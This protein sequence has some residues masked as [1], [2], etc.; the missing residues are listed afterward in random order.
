MARGQ[1]HSDNVGANDS[2]APESPVVPN[3]H[4]HYPPFRGVSGFVAAASMAFMRGA[5]TDLA[6]ELSALA[7]T[8]RA[9]DLGCGP[10]APTRALAKRVAHVTAIDP[11]QVMLAVA[12][13]IPASSNIDWTLGTAAS[14]PLDTETIDIVWALA[15]V[16]HWANIE[17]SIAEVFRVLRPGGRF[18]AIER[19]TQD[20]ASGHASHGWTTAQGELFARMCR[21]AGFEA[22]SATQHQNAQGTH[23]AVVSEKATGS[24]A[25]A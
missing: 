12:R 7:A 14:I 1:D 17:N 15:S 2:L 6:I 18:V 4:A 19:Q 25:C 23:V 16:H 11:A 5:S 3:H 24:H 22:S 10:G 8:D 20:G 13:L 21:D 9:V